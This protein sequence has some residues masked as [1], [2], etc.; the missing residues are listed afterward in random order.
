M[1]TGSLNSMAK[2]QARKTTRTSASRRG[3]RY[4]CRQCGFRAAHAAG[5]GRHRSA[6]HGV[7]SQRQRARA[8]T[9][10]RKATA[11]RSASG[12]AQL[13]RRLAALERRYD[14]LLGGLEQVLRRAK[15]K[16]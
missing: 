8:A 12:D 15:H 11:T 16:T 10:P 5:L 7:I 4:V 3:R 14:L 6:I 2:Q 9:A 13:A 1:Q